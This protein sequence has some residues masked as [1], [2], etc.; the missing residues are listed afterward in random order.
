[1]CLIGGTLQKPSTPE[2]TFD[3]A[4][5]VRPRGLPPS[6]TARPKSDVEPAGQNLPKSALRI[7]KQKYEAT[8]VAYDG[9]RRCDRELDQS[10]QP[11]RKNK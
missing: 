4:A 2:T 5:E 1:L 9:I 10:G 11:Y 3:I 7:R 8:I 6:S